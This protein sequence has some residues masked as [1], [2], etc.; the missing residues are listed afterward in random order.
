[1][2]CTDSVLTLT[3][4][5]FSDN[6]GQRQATFREGRRENGGG[7][8]KS[9]WT[10]RENMIAT[11]KLAKTYNCRLLKG[12]SPG[13]DSN[14]GFSY[15]WMKLITETTSLALVQVLTRCTYCRHTATAAEFSRR[16]LCV[17]SQRLA[18]SW[19]C[20]TRQITIQW[21]RYIKA[22]KIFSTCIYCKSI[23]MHYK[24]E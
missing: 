17:D 10:P 12:S 2:H 9:D 11:A 19:M 23:T 15:R 7:K 24:V 21:S 22:T 16:L 20:R 18:G 13:V 6:A 4:K 8:W 3:S 14:L 1:M 5:V